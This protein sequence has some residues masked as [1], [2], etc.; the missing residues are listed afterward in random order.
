MYGDEV[1]SA[2]VYGNGNEVTFYFSGVDMAAAEA[3]VSGLL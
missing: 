2:T 3:V 1:G